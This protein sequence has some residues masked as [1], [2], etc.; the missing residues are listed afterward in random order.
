MR[1][2]APAPYDLLEHT[3]DLAFRV[4]APDLARLFARAALA[5]HDVIADTAAAR[6]L[7]ERRIEVYGSNLEDVFV[8]FLEEAHFLFEAE[9]LL[10][11]EV[12]VSKVDITRPPPAGSARRERASRAWATARGERFDPAR[13]ELRRPVKAV[14]Y[15]DLA[16]EQ[17]P[18]GGF[19]A[20]VV[21]DL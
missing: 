11:A 19:A 15:H 17:L 6:P 18:T 4:E 16:I 1:E 14:T 13:H 7:A 8:R 12:E 2:R 5:L 21:V 3:A 10:L 9:R 20:R